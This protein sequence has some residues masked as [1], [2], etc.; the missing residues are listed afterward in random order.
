MWMTKFLGIELILNDRRRPQ[1]PWAAGTR[2]FV[3]NWW[4]H[5]KAAR[6]RLNER[7]PVKLGGGEC[8]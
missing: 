6:R 8:L 2:I 1:A 5:S 7:Y 4:I 3:R